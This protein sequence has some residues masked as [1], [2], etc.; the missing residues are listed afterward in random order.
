MRILLLSAYDAQSHKYWR[1]ALVDE[2]PEHHWTQ[3]VLPGRYFSW[4]IRGNSMQWAL[5]AK[6]TLDQPYDLVLATSMVDLASLKG[7]VANLANIPSILY[8]HENQFIYPANQSNKTRQLD[9]KMVT[10]YGALSADK[11]VFN[12]QYN[13]QS[14]IAGVD[15]LL[16]QLPEKMPI[17][18]AQLLDKK[19]SV[20]PVPLKTLYPLD[21][22]NPSNIANNGNTEHQSLWP[23]R[24]G[25]SSLRLIWAARWEYDKGPQQLQAILRQ[26]RNRNIDFKLCLVGQQ[27][28]QQPIEFEEIKKEFS[29]YLVQFGYVESRQQYLNWLAG[30]DMILSTALHE[31]QGISVLEA[32]QLGCIPV[33]PNRLVYPEMFGLDYLYESAPQE[34]KK[35]SVAAVNLI[36]KMA[37]K[38]DQDIASIP[39]V[40]HLLWPNMKEQYKH[41]LDFKA[42]NR[43]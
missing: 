27:F 9:P 2:F 36:Q 16:N 13:Q 39:F 10:L 5:G 30:G 17:D 14:F 7:F 1:E 25:R 12:S 18:V 23:K 43:P 24:E 35:E 4:R 15:E 6:A 41:L 34:H 31:F 33:L 37:L 20:L 3:L 8:F 38:I 26:L 40:E 21:P 32:V 28:R 19:S 22:R 11:L 29:T 42:P